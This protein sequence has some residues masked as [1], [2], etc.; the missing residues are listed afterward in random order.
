M[1][2][3]SVGVIYKHRF[4]PAKK[5]AEKLVAWLND[6]GLI[7]FFEEMG[8]NG[9]KEVNY[10]DP[11]SLPVKDLKWIIVLGGDGTLLGA[12]RKY[13]RHGIPILG[14][15]LGGL[16]FLT[17]IPLEKL[18]PSIEMV[19]NNSLEIEQRLM[20]ET[21]VIRDGKEVFRFQTL[22]DVVINKGALARIIE[23][24]VLI[25]D[26]FLT[27]FRSDG[28]IISTPTGSTGYNLAAGG[29]ILYPT[30][31]NVILTPICPFTL[32]NR[33][34]ILPES[35]VISIMMLKESEEKVSLTFDGQVGF[36]LLEGDKVIIYKSDANIRLFR[37]PDQTYYEI[38]RRKMKWGGATYN[39]D[40]D[41]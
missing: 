7:T 29:P 8:P 26:E 33:P 16:G 15:N 9:Q 25:N 2:E 4:E 30:I 41:N 13:G 12:S 32:T 17:C 5:E 19:L 27:T 20:L 28:L 3:F 37:S 40:G 39:K 14:V 24:D 31:S 10:D 38:L 22:N 11:A 1:N 36:D 34:I 35:A 21:R 6:R 23:L 18:Y